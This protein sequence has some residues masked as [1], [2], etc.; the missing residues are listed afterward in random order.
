MKNKKI[1]VV[2]GMNDFLVGGVQRLFVE[3]LRYFDRD[4]FEIVLITLFQFSD[5]QDFY[6]ELPPDIEI[7]R[8]NFMS[9]RDV[10]SWWQLYQLLRQL[11]PDIVVS[12]LFFS[13][14]VFRILKLFCGF[15]VIACE[16][17]TYTEKTW[18]QRRVDRIL[19]LWS[20]RIMAVSKTVAIFTSKQERIPYKKFAIIHNGVDIK[21]IQTELEQL[22]ASDV[23]KR[24][25]GFKSSDR[26]ILSVARLVPQKNHTLLLDGFALFYRTHPDYK[27][28]IVGGGGLQSMLE[29][30]ANELG[31]AD[32]AVF[33][34]TRQDIWKFYKICDFFVS[35]SL[36][37][38][39]G[40]AHAEALA[41]GIPVVTTKTAGPDV[42]IQ[43]GVNGYFISEYTPKAVADTLEKAVASDTVTMGAAAKESVQKYSIERSVKAYESLFA[44]AVL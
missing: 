36:I 31:I 37:E 30:Y 44:E 19:A 24:D 21:K 29:A 25:L 20:Y 26:I 8:L 1:K 34:G 32:A 17:N 43:E 42:L 2:F 4:T 38:G 39:F 3:Q 6:A 7:H 28:A 27:L 15:H 35:A 14:T 5:Q 11:K 12:S 10:R 33:F 9:V 23:L 40:I 13:N 22:P 41:C 16:H 18:A